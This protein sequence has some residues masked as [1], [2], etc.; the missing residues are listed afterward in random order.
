MDR[1]NLVTLDEQI[2]PNPA[3]ERVRLWTRQFLMRENPQL[4]RAGAVCPF[5][6]LGARMNT[7]RFGVSARRPEETV[8]IRRELRDAFDQFEQ[9]EHTKNAGVY[10]AIL[11]AFPT[12]AG[13]EGVA[14]L[15]RV[16]KSLHLASFLRARMI[17]LF[18][19]DAPEEGL[20]NKDFRPL[21]APLPVIAIRSLV[22]Q[23]A[24]FVVRHPLL[25]PAY[26]YNFPLAGPREL[27]ALRLRK[28]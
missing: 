18:Y 13:A 17:G 22:A 3:L 23:D 14:A 4:G 26:F 19:P 10:R 21:R 16:K 24:A 8:A 27:A 28:A 11:I 12:C 1:I 7:L 15:M 20:W 6:P 5:T 9:I 2:A 25:A